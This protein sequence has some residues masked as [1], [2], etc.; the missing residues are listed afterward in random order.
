M[1][2]DPDVIKFNGLK[3]SNGTAS[4]TKTPFLIGVAGGTASGKVSDYHNKNNNFI[5]LF[6]VNF[7]DKCGKLLKM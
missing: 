3:I 1:S 5:S 6:E 2:N 4:E 7:G